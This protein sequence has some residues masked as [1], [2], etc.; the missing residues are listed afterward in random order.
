MLNKDKKSKYFIFLSYE[1]TAI[2]E[3]LE[4]MTLKG[5]MLKS[6]SGHI[7][8][9]TKTEPKK[10][11]YLIEPICK[12]SSLITE[13]SIPSIPSR[14]FY[15]STGWKYVCKKGNSNIFYSEESSNSYPISTNENEKFKCLFKS[16]LLEIL[17]N[18]II[19]FLLSFSIYNQIS[20]GNITYILTSNLT[21]M[22]IL[23]LILFT[24]TNVF[25]TILF[26]SWSIKTKKAINNGLT[27]P[28][29]S[30][31]NLKKKN[32]IKKVINISIISFI[33][34][35]L[36]TDIIEKNN[37]LNES[38]SILLAILMFF[39]IFL[40]NILNRKFI[41][42]Y[43]YSKRTNT[44]I[45]SISIIFS[46]FL[47]IFVTLNIITVI[48]GYGFIGKNN[49]SETTTPL[50]LNNFKIYNNESKNIY[51]SENSSILAKQI[52]YS[53]YIDDNNSLNY[54]LF[55]S[56]QKFIISAVE[57]SLIKFKTKL[58]IEHYPDFAIKNPIIIDEVKIYSIENPMN[59]FIFVSNN[60]ILNINK[61]FKN[62]SDEEFIQIILKNIF[63][64]NVTL[65]NNQYIKNN[66][67]F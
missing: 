5:W 43:K 36:F 26:I 35:I 63:N 37:S 38:L 13:K 9:F 55:E 46:F 34:I 39:V 51:V 53:D 31:K 16:S 44:I 21:L 6:I 49:I 20:N 4:E 7:F 65:P 32:L 24:I 41:K 15:E 25:E 10:L 60:K 66:N 42:K 12:N 27:I 8:K 30:F 67:L 59:T 29:Y 47:V 18:F 11:K 64:K 52:Y 45:K 14:E 3:Y 62:I 56:D 1:Y 54:L 19:I 58:E 50:T 33:L 57:K 40:V 17:P 22:S 61:S 28:H 23:A 2:K 48:A